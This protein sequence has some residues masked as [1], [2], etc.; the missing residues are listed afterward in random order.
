MKSLACLTFL[1]VTSFLA[2]AAAPNPV[3]EMKT[4]LGTITIEV[5]QDKA[6]IT[7]ANFLK[8]VEK[9]YY[10]GT[11]FHRVIP[12]FM[13]Q[14]GGFARDGADLVE[15]ETQP[16]IRNEAKASGLRNEPGTLAMARTSDPNSASAQFFINVR[17]P[18]SPSGYNDFLDFDKARDGVGYAVFGR[19]IKGMDVVEKINQVATGRAV[20]KGRMPSGALAPQPSSDV[21]TKDVTVESVRLVEAGKTAE[22]SKPAAKPE[23]KK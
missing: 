21:P 15:K 4:S 11:V 14:G 8:Y 10:D 17:N 19:V 1:A 9:K 13:N 5:A 7:A 6:P 16:G 20:L 18:N 22:E 23:E 2:S 3:V 12:G